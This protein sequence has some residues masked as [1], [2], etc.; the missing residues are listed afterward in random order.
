MHI[1]SSFGQA[2]DFYKKKSRQL[3]VY[4]MVDYMQVGSYETDVIIW[5]YLFL[6]PTGRLEYYFVESLASSLSRWSLPCGLSIK[7]VSAALMM[8]HSDN[9]NDHCFDIL[10]K[11][12]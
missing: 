6:N 11:I 3:S 2:C 1:T 4:M 8:N 7:G 9:D 10:S 5:R 12:I